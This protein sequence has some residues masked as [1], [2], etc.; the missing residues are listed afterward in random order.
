M[1][2]DSGR[3]KRPV[4]GQRIDIK[5][6]PYVVDGAHDILFHGNIEVILRKPHGKTLYQSVWYPT[7]AMS[8]PAQIP[9][10]VK[11]RGLLSGR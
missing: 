3:H 6:V 9:K 10:G 1:F 2:R 4:V 11:F 7:G 5:G 8:T